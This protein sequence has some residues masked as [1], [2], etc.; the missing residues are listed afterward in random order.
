MSSSEAYHSRIVSWVNGAD[1]KGPHYLLLLTEFA[2]FAAGCKVPKD[3][4]GNVSAAFKRHAERLEAEY[5]KSGVDGNIDDAIDACNNVDEAMKEQD[6]QDIG[7]E[8]P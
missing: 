8:Q 7:N 6:K 2:N 4:R 5:P 3:H 1:I